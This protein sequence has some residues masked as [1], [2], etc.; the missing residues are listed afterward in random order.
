MCN[1]MTPD[2]LPDADC[3][4]IS[5]LSLTVLENGD[6]DDVP[7]S[8]L[9]PH[10]RDSDSDNDSCVFI[11]DEPN[12][13]FGD[14]EAY[15]ADTDSLSPDWRGLPTPRFRGRL[16]EK[17]ETVGGSSSTATTAT[18]PH[19]F[20]PRTGWLLASAWKNPREDTTSSLAG[21]STGATVASSPEVATS[22]H[23][24]TDRCCCPCNGERHSGIRNHI[25]SCPMSFENALAP[26]RSQT[27]RENY[28][29]GLQP[30]HIH[31]NHFPDIYRPIAGGESAS[32]PR[33]RSESGRATQA[34]SRAADSAFLAS[35]GCPR[36][37]PD[38]YSAARGQEDRLAVGASRGS[39]LGDA[40]RL[41]MRL[42]AGH[43]VNLPVP[44]A[45]SNNELPLSLPH[46]TPLQSMSKEETTKPPA[47][48]LSPAFGSLAQTRDQT[49]RS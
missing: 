24:Q 45:S 21:S 18:Q 1:T 38:H 39:V 6:N 41:A 17:A 37:L 43:P 23:K 4:I 22:Y 25:I 49:Y 31:D 36:L 27:R 26:I 35:I 33:Q 15:A 13:Y 11:L 40:M 3:D 16:C 8:S 28:S 7:E 34:E 47:S 29:P 46:G 32:S 2:T 5:P 48:L 42:P 19:D 20:K 9:S 44:L 10:V 14:Y 30:R 12:D